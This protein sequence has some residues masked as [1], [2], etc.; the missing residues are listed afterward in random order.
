MED[1]G[2]GGRLLEVNLVCSFD[3]LFYCAPWHLLPPLALAETGRQ[4]VLSGSDDDDDGLCYHQMK[5]ER[6]FFL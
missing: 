5:Q 4:R 1:E 2:D 3:G 6:I